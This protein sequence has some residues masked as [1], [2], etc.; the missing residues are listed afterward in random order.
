MD[1]DSRNIHTGKIEWVIGVQHE[2]AGLAS[3]V[4]NYIT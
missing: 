2:M 1:H 3:V 4:S